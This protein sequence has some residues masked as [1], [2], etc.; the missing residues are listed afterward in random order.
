MFFH[1]PAHLR[2][3]PDIASWVGSGRSLFVTQGGTFE[4]R[5]EKRRGNG[6]R[7][8]NKRQRSKTQGAEPET[9]HANIAAHPPPTIPP[10]RPPSLDPPTP[11]IPAV[12][13]F[14]PLSFV[15][16]VERSGPRKGKMPQENADQAAKGWMKRKSSPAK[17]ELVF[18]KY[19]QTWGSPPSSYAFW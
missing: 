13:F 7:K 15:R 9:N 2:T 4:R 10:A 19:N 3:P 16:E 6:E 14:S 1:V 11:L 12:L 18:D 8:I 17:H 5:R